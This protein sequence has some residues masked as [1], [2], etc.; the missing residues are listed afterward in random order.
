MWAFLA[1]PFS[2]ETGTVTEAQ[3]VEKNPTPRLAVRYKDTIVAA[4]QEQ[5]GY[6]NIMMVP[7]MERVVINMGIGRAVETKGRLEHGVK[8]LSVIA[9]Q[10]PITTKARKSL[11]G[12][13][14]REGNPIGCAV[15]LR[16]GRMWEFLDRLISVAI[17][18]IRDFRGLPTKFDGRG[19][20]TMGLAEQSVF[21]EISLDKVEFV[22]GMN[23]TFVTTA[24]TDEEGLF[25][26]KQI[27]MPF[28]K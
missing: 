11:A 6:P 25:F 17:P 24:R 14:L 16:G 8:D 23:V 28:R 7:R 3:T 10:K 27:G 13:K 5:F 2:I 26:L 4:L 18:R 12:F 9:G 15:T 19:N 21:P 20:Y 22:Q 1:A